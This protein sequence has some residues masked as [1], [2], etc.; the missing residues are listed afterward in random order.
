MDQANERPKEK[1]QSQLDTIVPMEI[2][3]AQPF[4]SKNSHILRDQIDEYVQGFPA[5]KAHRKIL[6]KQ[7]NM[8]DQSFISSKD[9]NEASE[10]RK[11]PQQEVQKNQMNMTGGLNITLPE[12][13]LPVDMI[14][15]K[16]A[17]KVALLKND[18]N[19]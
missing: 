6:A 16:K 8:T 5:T 4:F 13:E 19:P 3:R 12:K 1:L 11:L 10:E 9:E 17:I 15:L 2:V 14:R 7:Y 18:N